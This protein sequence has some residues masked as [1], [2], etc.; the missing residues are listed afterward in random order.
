MRG[1]SWL[2]MVATSLVWGQ[3]IKEDAKL[4]QNLMRQKPDQFKTILEKKKQFEIQIIYT[5]INRDAENRPSFKTFEFNVDTNR[6]FYP[7]STVK[8]P[9][10]LLALEKLNELNRPEINKH[11][12]I[13]FD[14]VYSGQRWARVDTTA[15]GGVPTIAH[16][17][18]KI[19]IASDN[20]AFNRLYE[21]LGQRESNERLWKKGYHARILHR[22]DRRLSPD[23][24]RHTEPVRF[25]VRD[26]ILYQQPM[27]V[28]DSIVVNQ[29]VTKG[30][31][32]Y[33]KGALIRKPFDMSYRNYFHL[34]DQH[35]MLKVI[36][37]PN[38]VPEKSRF[39][40]TNDDRAFVLKHMSQLP[41]E[42]L[43]P[44]YY[45]DSTYTDA[46]AKALLYGADTT[47]IPDHIRIF[48]KIGTAYGFVIDNAYIVDFNE[49]IEFLLSAVIYTNKDE[50]FNDDKYEYETVAQPFMKNLGQLIYDYERS[51]VK[52]FKPNL[53][54]FKFEYDLKREWKS[55]RDAP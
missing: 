20:V 33:E 1:F 29:K 38:S 19:L 16:Y 50:I 49:D 14:S 55:L 21:W 42:T 13:F 44:A 31:G 10:I 11:T 37:F 15:E 26:S 46:Y 27:L 40:L 17:S 34:P 2:F 6:Y 36:V 4:L 35:D 25:A 32:Y 45:K 7:A 41:T 53:A 23:E 18:K 9:A 3:T 52:K 30:K 8:L 39:N 51:R 12:P 43:Y 24:N 22:L 28:N 5:Q 47:R 48:N 54:E